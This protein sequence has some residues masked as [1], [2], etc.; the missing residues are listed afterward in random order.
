MSTTNDSTLRVDIFAL[1]ITVLIPFW[2]TK[3]FDF[4]SVCCALNMSAKSMPHQ[5][6]EGRIYYFCNW[7]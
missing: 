2:G 7:T 5:E 3:A 6:K 1:I 4:F